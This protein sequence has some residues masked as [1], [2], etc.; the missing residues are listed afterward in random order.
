MIDEHG[1][2]VLSDLSEFHG[3]DLVSVLRD[4]SHSPRT[5]IAYLSALPDNSAL[6]ASIRQEPRGWGTDRHLFA[7]VVDAVQA[8]TWVTAAASGGRKPRKPK[9]VARPKRASRSRV[10]RVADL[11]GQNRS[12]ETSLQE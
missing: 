4:Y 8:N 7:T 6:A 3:L 2:A 9:P 11:A 10:L 1:V 12:T 5:L